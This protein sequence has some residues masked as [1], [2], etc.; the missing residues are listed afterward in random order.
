MIRINI[1]N[2]AYFI[3][4]KYSIKFTNVN[5]FSYLLKE[6]LYN[7]IVI[8]CIVRRFVL[9]TPNGDILNKKMK[10]YVKLS[11]RRRRQIRSFC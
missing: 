3:F 8:K 2:N 1:F 11:L 7:M 5:F 10:H 6:F 4:G 9:G